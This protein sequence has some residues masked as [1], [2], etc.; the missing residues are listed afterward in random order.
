MGV[1]VLSFRGSAGCHVLPARLHVYEPRCV[2]RR[3]RGRQP[4]RQRGNGDI[5]GALLALT[6]SCLS[7]GR[8]PFSLTGLP[9]TGGFI[10]KF[11]LFAAV[12]KQKYYWLALI[13][14]L[15]SVVAL[16]YYARIIK[17]M[18][19]EEALDDTKISVQ[20]FPVVLLI[21]LAIPT[22]LLGIYWAPVK[23]LVDLSSQ[24]LHP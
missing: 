14:V 21:L 12:I 22:I 11:Y 20:V 9:P 10:G 18:F 3:D 7:Y 23:N 2:P 6:S 15:N 24:L 4:P 13:G 19:L 16:Y 8:I 17:T 1:V 5:Q